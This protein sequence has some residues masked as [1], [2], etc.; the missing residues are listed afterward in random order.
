MK[1][2][3]R[4]T[5]DDSHLLSEL[6]KRTFI[7]SH[8]HSAT[9]LEIDAYISKAYDADALTTELR[10]QENKYIIIYKNNQPA[11]YSKII[12]NCP[13]ENSKIE[14]LAKMD[15]FYLL[16]DFYGQNLGSELFN[17]NINF[18]KENKQ[19]GMWLYV[20]K[21]NKRAVNFYLKQGFTIIGTHDFMISETH[22]NPNHQM[23]LSL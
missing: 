12:L 20:W 14:N 6:A 13:Y 1:L 4:A 19:S 5:E 11:G 2:I 7:E 23:L 17:F 10:N 3:V 15:R 8:G 22:S 21:E 16:K 9:A 18:I